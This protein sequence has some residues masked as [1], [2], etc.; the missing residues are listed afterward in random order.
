MFFFQSVGGPSAIYTVTVPVSASM[1]SQVSDS[2]NVSTTVSQE[3]SRNSDTR[4][5]RFTESEEDFSNLLGYQVVNFRCY[6]LAKSGGAENFL[7]IFF[8]QVPATNFRKLLKVLCILTASSGFA[9]L[10]MKSHASSP[11]A[12]I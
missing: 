6:R 9:S 4:K 11:K 7:I 1:S 2:G 10:T 8:Q 5:R 12:V 3:L